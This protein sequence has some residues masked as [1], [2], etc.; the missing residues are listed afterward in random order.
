MKIKKAEK[1]AASAVEEE[2]AE[3]VRVR[4]L[5]AKDDGAPNFYM[6]QFTFAPG[7]H[8]ARHS[9]QWE[10]EVYIL[11]GSGAVVTADARREIAA[12]DCVFVA[13]GELHQFVN[14]GG[15]ELKLLCLVPKTAV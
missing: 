15:D 11:A 7:G 13:P 12:G 6:R 10:H 9:H 4:W 2:G 8:T 5:I 14:T 3:G 1:V